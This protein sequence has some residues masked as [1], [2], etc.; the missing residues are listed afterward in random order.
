VNRFGK[1]RPRRTYTRVPLPTGA[2]A[3]PPAP[4]FVAATWLVARRDLWASLRSKSFIISTAVILLGLLAGFFVAAAVGGSGGPIPGL[5]GSGGGD[6]EDG[7]RVA[8]A[9]GDLAAIVE[10]IPGVVAVEA[11]SEAEATE[12]VRAGD[13]D[14]A[15]FLPQAPGGAPRVV[16]DR[17]APEALVEA[18]TTNPEVTLLDPPSMDAMAR[19]FLSLAFGIVYLM[20]GAMFG[21]VIAQNTVVEK[22]T[23]IVEI[24]VAAV[25]TRAMLAGKILGGSILAV[26]ETLAI[27]AVCLVGMQMNDM[28]SLLATLTAPMWW[29]VAFFLV[30]FVMYAAMF[31]AAG[32]LVSRIEDLGSASMPILFLVMI[33]YVLVIALNGS[34]LAMTVMS[35][36]PFTSPVAMPVQMVLGDA[37]AWEAV[38][39]LAVLTVTALLIGLAATRI[40]ENSVLQTGS[41]IKARQALRGAA[42]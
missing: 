41:R 25:P 36:V 34:P 20:M 3:E 30:G 8:V 11:G 28:T 38:A 23:R 19:Y 37:G 39:S 32:A 24:L 21:Q 33:P 27:V 31:S 2:F 17:E 16:A 18:L 7:L 42:R 15:V 13:V 35:Y 6:S 9:D 14:A 29:Y 12:S 4:N 22:Q 40:Y 1:R 26:G 5:E 10:T